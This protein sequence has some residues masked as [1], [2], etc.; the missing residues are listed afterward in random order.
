M[1]RASAAIA[2][3]FVCASLAWGQVAI[4]VGGVVL[5]RTAA[6]E[7]SAESYRFSLT[8]RH[9]A[10]TAEVA[11][12]LASGIADRIEAATEDTPLGTVTPRI[13]DRVLSLSE[14]SATVLR[15]VDWIVNGAQFQG[16]DDRQKELGELLD[17]FQE[18]ART[19][20]A[21]DVEGPVPYVNDVQPYEDEAVAKA[22]RESLLPAASASGVVNAR[23]TSAEAVEILSV[24]WK[25]ASLNTLTCTARVRIRYAYEAGL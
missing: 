2:I 25:I 9:S 22:L 1:M 15:T 23:V 6:I 17:M 10:D 20:D 16:N 19:L 21:V 8:L 18:L 7:V 24:R 3:G 12:G 14:S 11:I 13:G 4:P 5:T